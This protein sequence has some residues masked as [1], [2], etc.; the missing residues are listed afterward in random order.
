MPRRRAPA[1]PVMPPPS[2]RAMTSKRSTVSVTRK[3]ERRG[4]PGSDWC[5]ASGDE[6]E[7]IGEP[8]QL[9]SLKDLLGVVGVGM[10]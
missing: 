7:A 2:Q 10:R 3:G 4:N 9:S 5:F 1:W 6:V 8:R